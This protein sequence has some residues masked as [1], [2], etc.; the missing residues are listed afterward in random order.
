MTIPF[1]SETNTSTANPR[2]RQAMHLREA[3][4]R[5]A[6]MPPHRAVPR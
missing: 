2:V 5:L 1:S 3:D 4:A 6:A